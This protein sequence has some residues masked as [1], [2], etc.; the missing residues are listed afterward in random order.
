[1]D[2]L[3]RLIVF[4]VGLF[5]GGVLGYLA[6]TVQFMQ[7]EI[8]QVCEENRA[9]HRERDESGFMR[10]PIVA[11]VMSLLI[12]FIVVFAAWQSHTVSK[13][14]QAAQAEIRKVA[15]CN[16]RYLRSQADYLSV[17]LEEDPPATEKERGQA[18]RKYYILL[19]AYAHSELPLD[20]TVVVDEDI[21]ACIELLK[22]ANE[23]G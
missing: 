21:K 19:N 12:L 14:V 20:E 17:L 8:H 22:E 2:L 16:Q 7:K 18:L 15:T 11:D 9:F 3:E 6:R 13:D 5:I 1:M 4:G 23:N 10:Y